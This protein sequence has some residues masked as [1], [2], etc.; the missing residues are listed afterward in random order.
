[1]S[2]SLGESNHGN[3]F[4]WKVPAKQL[5]PALLWVLRPQCEVNA[6][7]EFLLF[8]QNI[9]LMS[10]C[11]NFPWSHHPSNVGPRC[12]HDPA[13]LL[14]FCDCPDCF[15]KMHPIVVELGTKRQY[16]RSNLLSAADD[17]VQTYNSQNQEPCRVAGYL[18]ST[19]SGG[20]EYPSWL[21]R[22]CRL[23]SCS[24]YRSPPSVGIQVLG[25][26]QF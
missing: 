8:N 14:G 21:W 22:H 26:E 4:K 23:I 13:A 20:S 12:N 10:V 16:V 19:C 25:S 3:E 1:M 24:A 2:Y 9:L 11:P 17:Y 7:V 5:T 18:L 15:R 6:K